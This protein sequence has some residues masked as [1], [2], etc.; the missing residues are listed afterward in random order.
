MNKLKQCIYTF[1]LLLI[2]LV[3]SPM[4]YK[5]I[6]D[7]SAEKKK[8]SSDKPPVID[9][10]ANDPANTATTAAPP[11]GASQPVTEGAPQ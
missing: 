8:V 3:A 11:D 2:C 7:T 6:W 10:Y 1:T 9:I 5:K 4:I